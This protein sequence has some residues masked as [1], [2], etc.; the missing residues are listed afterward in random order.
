MRQWLCD[1]SIMCT[2]HLLGEHCE[3]HMFVG[4][5][6]KGTSIQGYLDNNLLEPEFLVGRHT[7]LVNEMIKR[8]MNHQSNLPI[9]NIDNLTDLQRTTTI[10]RERSLND[11][12]TRC[13]LC[14][15]K[16]DEQLQG[17]KK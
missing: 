1:T 2:Q 12:L 3:A 4:T 10:D 11:L 7:E 6:N 14:K 17:K 9:L 16:N 5:I 13:P 8:G 15:E